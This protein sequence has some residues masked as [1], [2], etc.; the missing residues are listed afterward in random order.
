MQELKQSYLVEIDGVPMPDPI[1][2]ELPLDDLDSSDSSL[3][4]SGVQI[5][6][7]RSVAGAVFHKVYVRAKPF[8]LF[9]TSGRHQRT[10]K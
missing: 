1:T 7:L 5:R 6:S 3:S 2:Y 9:G 4:E 10:G 8:L